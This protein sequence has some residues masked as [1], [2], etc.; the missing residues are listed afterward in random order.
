MPLPI[1]LT[2]KLVDERGHKVGCHQLALEGVDDRGSTMQRRTPW[3]L[4]QVPVR[5]A[6]PQAQV[7]SA[8]RRQR[9]A[10]V[11]AE[12]LLG[13]QMVGSATLPEPGRLCLL[14]SLT[15]ANALETLLHGVSQGLRDDA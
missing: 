5:R 9:T 12:R 7:V 14:H 4:A 11:T 1:H 8:N 2:M 3:R 10:A 6:L 15:L 13:Q